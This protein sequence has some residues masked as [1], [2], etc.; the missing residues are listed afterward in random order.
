M[1]SPVRIPYESFIKIDRKSDTSIYLQIANQLINAIQR[2]FLPFGT[3]LPGTRTFSEMLEIHRNTAVAVYDELSAQGWTESFPNK[4]T[5]V[6]GKDEEKPIKVN[7]FQHNNLQNYPETTGFLFKTSNIL[8]NPFE[9]SDCE[10]VF[11]DGVPDIRLTQIAQHSRFYSSILKRK[12]NQKISGHYNH[13]GSE[14]FKEHLS[15]YL[16]LSRGLPISK[17]NLLITRSTEMSIYIVSEILLSPGDV[18]LVAALSY[19]SVNMIFMKAGVQM[20]SIPIDEEGII[21]ENVREACKKQKI[22][23]LYLTPHHHYPTTVAIS[24]QRRLELLELANEYGFIILEDDYDYEFHYDK[25]PILPLASADTNGMVIYIG[26]FGKSLAPGFRTG[27]IVAPEN[28]MAEMRKYLGIIDRQGDILM[29]RALGEMIEEGEINRY[30]KKSLKV[31]QERR[32]YLAV[33]LKENLENLITFQIP[34]GG[35]AIWLEWNVPINLMQLSRGCAQDNLFIP[36][37]LLYQNKNL[38]AMRLGFGDLNADEMEKSVDV[39]SNN[40]KRLI[41]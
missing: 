35:L 12:S 1:D 30:L 14:F 31:Y 8:D 17:N 26:S 37:T 39:F 41:E 7:D 6:I 20:V 40:V 21:V 3:K 38:T 2:G 32:D 34:S 9:H 10:Y 23:M 36:K 19:F 16:N 11:N 4:G 22:R 29:E 24:A 27:F 5:F 13:D 33:L 15:R 25:S 18:V 28:L